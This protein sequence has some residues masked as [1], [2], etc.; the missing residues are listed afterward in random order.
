M[1]L[2]IL[3]NAEPCKLDRQR[4]DCA[5][6]ITI[7]KHLCCTPVVRCTAMR[8]TS[9]IRAMRSTETG[10][11]TRSAG[12]LPEELREL[13]YIHTRI[14]SRHG[15]GIRDFIDQYGHVRD[16]PVAQTN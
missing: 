8:N 2:Y 4:D 16:T 7:G 12:Q 6:T 9:C 5:A 15:I 14:A 10:Q 11:Q 13:V 3:Q 1:P